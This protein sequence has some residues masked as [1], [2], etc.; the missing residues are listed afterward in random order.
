MA[1]DSPNAVG[2]WGQIYHFGA[3]LLRSD[4]ADF[5]DAILDRFSSLSQALHLEI[6]S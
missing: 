5:R 1:L 3:G 6:F 2:L 4:L